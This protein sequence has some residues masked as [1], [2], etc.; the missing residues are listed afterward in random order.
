MVD[1]AG[2]L[3]D[4]GADEIVAL[5]ADLGAA[6]HDTTTTFSVEV[7]FGDGGDMLVTDDDADVDVDAILAG[8][9]GEPSDWATAPATTPV[10]EDTKD[11]ASTE[12]T[13]NLENGSVPIDAL[14]I[15]IIFEDDGSTSGHSL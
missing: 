6:P 4:A 7:A 8:W 11:T 3:H 13:H 12:I 14:P 5:L 2:A 1:D 9:T 10:A 15:K